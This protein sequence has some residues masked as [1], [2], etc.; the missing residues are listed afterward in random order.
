MSPSSH[1]KAESHSPR[2]SRIQFRQ[3]KKYPTPSSII[4]FFLSRIDQM[5]QTCV[6]HLLKKQA[7]YAYKQYE[8]T[9]L[10]IMAPMRRKK[11]EQKIKALKLKLRITPLWLKSYETNNEKKGNIRTLWDKGRQMKRFYFSLQYTLH[12]HF[13]YFC[14][15]FCMRQTAVLLEAT[16][17]T[18]Q[19]IYF[20]LRY[21]YG[22]PVLLQARKGATSVVTIKYWGHVIWKYIN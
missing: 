18:S 17:A 2:R 5:K 22:C 13:G 15:P 3:G 4:Y 14:I 16:T 12:L 21:C 8:N 11:S 20:S 6:P 9:N 19:Q 10:R 7:Q 1:Y